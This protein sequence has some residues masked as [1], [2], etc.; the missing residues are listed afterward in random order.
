MATRLGLLGGTFDPIHVAHLFMGALA[1]D[2]LSLF[3]VIF[4][5]AGK[6]PHKQDVTITDHGHRLHMVRA[7]VKGEPLFEVSDLE[8]RRNAPSYTIE[9]VRELLMGAER[10]TE[11]YLIVGSDSLLEIHTWKDCRE[12]LSLVRL[13]VY[14]RPGFDPSACDAVSPGR[15]HLLQTGGLDFH[16][17]STAIRDRAASGRSIRYLVPRA[18]EEYITENNLY[19]GS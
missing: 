3:K 1:A 5:P 2:E 18:V 6:P 15:V 4:M 11:L 16:L 8:L 10:G 19:G 13:A 9:T 14:P 7:A 12:L 17:S